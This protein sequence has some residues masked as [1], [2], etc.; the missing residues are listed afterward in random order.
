[1]GAL[2]VRVG[3][4]RGSVA[5][6]FVPVVA[7]IAGVV[8]RDEHIAALSLVGMVLVVARRG[9][10]RAAP[11]A[12]RPPCPQTEVVG[13][14]PEQVGAATGRDAAPV[15]RG[16]AARAGFAGRRC[17]PPA[18]TARRSST[19]FRTDSSIVTTEPASVPSARRAAPS[20]RRR[21]TLAD[22]T[23]SVTSTASGRAASASRSAAGWTCTRSAMNDGTSRAVVERGAGEARRAVVQRAH[24]VEEVRHHPCAR[25]GGRARVVVRRGAVAERDDDAACRERPR[26]REAGIGFGRERDDAHEARE[27]VAAARGA[28]RDRPVARARAGARRARRRGT[29]LRGGRRAPRALRSQPA[30]SRSSVG[31]VGV[32]RRA[33]RGSARTRVQPPS[34]SI[35]RPSRRSSSTDAV[36]KSIAPA[37]L[38]WRSMNPGA[39]SASAMADARSS[40]SAAGRR[41]R[42]RRCGLAVDDDPGRRRG[43]AAVAGDDPRARRGPA[44]LSRG[45]A[46][47]RRAASTRPNSVRG[48]RRRIDVRAGRRSTTV[49]RDLGDHASPARSARR[50]NS[51]SNRSLP[52]RHAA[53][54]ASTA[55]RSIAFIPCVSE[56][57]RPNST[58]SSEREPGGHEL[59]QGRPVVARAGAALRPDDDRG[60]VGAVD[61]LDRDVEEA[62]VVVVD[63]EVDDDDGRA[64]AQTRVERGAVVGD[65]EMLDH[66]DFG[67]L[68]GE[69]MRDRRAVPSVEPFSQTMTSNGATPARGARRRRRR[70]MSRGAPPR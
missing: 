3:A 61:P 70:P 58:R 2:L 37:P 69:A 59:A 24:A 53:R 65:G 50:I 34:A 15:G 52:K 19:R 57:R 56:T 33:A 51:V 39:S 22:G 64:H 43:D 63:V 23:R 68:V 12:R 27:P 11:I 9:C 8:F 29:V 13:V 6:Y 4:A 40:H 46:T 5:V 16:R 25:V 55:A 67:V 35:R 30:A 62:E 48:T 49:D 38:T 36:A 20:R 31:V 21:T 14:E 54:S 1:M 45:R 17:A 10:S 47:A 66:D 18:P 26:R 7:V 60:T 32:E 44:S 41:S 42:P 28:S